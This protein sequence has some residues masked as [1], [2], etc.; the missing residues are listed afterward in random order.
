[1]SEIGSQSGEANGRNALPDTVTA[2]MSFAPVTE[3]PRTWPAI[4]GYTILDELGRGG[5]GVVYRARQVGL[6]RLVALKMIRAGSCAGADERIRFRTEAEAVARLQHPNIVHIYDV[7]EHEGEPFFSL[8]FCSGGSLAARLDGTPLPPDEAAQMVQTIAGAVEH[9]HGRGIVHRDLKPGNVLLAVSDQQSV[10]SDVHDQKAS[11]LT[12]DSCLL[13]AVPK[14]ADF[15]LAKKLDTET[16]QTQSGAILGTPSYMAPE[17]TGSHGGTIGPSADIYALG[18]ILYELLTGRPPFKAAT[19]FDTVLQVATAEPVPPSRLNPKVSRDLET[20]CLRCLQKEPARRYASALELA[21]DLG[22]FL[23]REPIRARPVSWLERSAKW[24][25]RRPAVAALLAGLL[26]ALLGLVGGGIW[27][28]VHLQDALT[29][30]EVERDQK[31]K[32]RKDALE[33][34]AKE[35][36]AREKTDEALAISTTMLAQTH[37]NTGNLVLAGDILEQVKPEFRWGGWSSLKRQAAGSYATLYGHTNYVWSVAFSPDGMLV[38]SGAEDH[39]VRLWDTA[40]GRAV[41]TLRGH[42]NR[43]MSVAFS[44]DGLRLASAGMDQTVR[45]WSTESATEIHTFR[46]HA[47]EVTA[48]AFSP[49]GLLLASTCHDQT[50]KLWDVK[51]KREVR[52]MRGHG[53]L[54]TSVAFSPDGLLLASAGHDQTIR[55]WDPRDGKEVRILRG[56]AEV[57]HS[58]V[59][60]PDGLLLASGANDRT[61]KLWDVKTGREVRTLHGHGHRVTGVAFSADGALVASASA[62]ATARLWEV[63]TGRERRILRGHTHWVTSVAFSPVGPVLASAS[64]DNTVKLWNTRPGEDIRTLQGHAKAVTSLAFGRGGLLA[65]AGEDHTVK[66][67]NIRTGREIRTL[68]GHGDRVFAVALSPDGKLLASGGA[69]RTIIKLWETASGADIRTLRGQGEQVTGLAFSPDGL[70]LASCGGFAVRLWDVPGG[71]EVRS[72]NTPNKTVWSVAF[73]PDG[74]SLASGGNDQ[75]VTI[76]DVQSGR[77]LHAC[78]GHTDE[79]RSVAFSPDGRHV[80][81]AG[82]DETVRIWEVETGQ[83]MRILKGHKAWVLGVGFSPDGLL[84]ASVG[85]HKSINGSRSRGA[86]DHSL[87]LWDARSGQEVRTLPGHTASV[88]AVAFSTDGLLLACAGYD[89]TIKVWDANTDVDVRVLEGHNERVTRVAFS[90]DGRLLASASLDKTVKLWDIASGRRLHTLQGHSGWVSGI[91]FN[92]DGRLLASAAYDGTIRLWDVH[93]AREVHTLRGKNPMCVAFS[94]D[95]LLLASAGKGGAVQLWDAKTGQPVRVFQGQTEWTKFVAFSSDGSVV[96]VKDARGGIQAWEVATG[97]PAPNDTPVNWL[98]LGASSPDEKWSAVPCSP[99]GIL[100]AAMNPAVGKT[101]DFCRLLASPDLSWH[102]ELARDHEAAKNWFALVWHRSRLARHEPGNGANW[103]GLVTACM[104]AGDFGPALKLGDELIRDQPRQAPLYARRAR[105]RARLGRFNDAAMD[106]L[107]ALALVA[108]LTMFKGVLASKEAEQRRQL[109][110]LAGRTY[111]IDMHSAAFDSE[112]KLLD[113][114]GTLLAENDDV[115]PDNLD[116]QLIFTPAVDGSYSIAAGCFAKDGTGPFTVTVRSIQGKWNRDDLAFCLAGSVERETARTEQMKGVALAAT[117][118]FAAAAVHL[119]K[120]IELD[121]ENAPA[122]H[123]LAE[124]L[125]QQDK[126]AE[127]RDATLAYL[128]WLSPGDQQRSALQNRLRLC[129]LLSRSGIT[130]TT[131][132][133]S[134]TATR[135]EQ[136]HQIKLVTGTTYI[137]DMRSAAF[138]CYLKLLDAT[139][140]LLFENDDV[141]EAIILDSRL[142]FTPPAAGT[143]T[144]VAGSFGNH[145]RGEYVLRIR[146]VPGTATP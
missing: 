55:L 73:S 4:A 85:G 126:L 64:E 84:L 134:L 72:F 8:E 21:D 124:V 91:A 120:A 81:S 36:A 132:K 108:N 119:R 139:G 41:R 93:S 140:R 59:F 13:K 62:D 42:A 44:P 76:W 78:T 1:M 24:A 83:E 80:A 98:F 128:K 82:M 115:A 32:A 5:M 137:V 22:R 68:S 45:L 89:R 77:K 106:N 95:G 37:L 143:Y 31:D 56:H 17:Q 11:K 39:T 3:P 65:S 142:I 131:L 114:N 88:T 70:L 74:R 103:N 71:R 14:I 35:K 113:G 99:N 109:T 67:W 127:A 79:V 10:I 19:A 58:V 28:T 102:D 122:Q 104:Q 2:D 87:R 123:H 144:I 100:L 30:A 135:P 18:A 47:S 43:V 50:I 90:P 53:N 49:D 107:A 121:P 125:L 63:A 34:A 25:K 146:T 48:V 129:E 15:G 138:D 86:E 136:R 12:A 66:L 111:I 101:P 141:V 26:L 97:K 112:L 117:N 6:D 110:L 130:Q 7:G 20:I 40:S 94:P 23:A 75:L 133:G 52:T 16:G 96:A 46:G 92:P 145:G 69:E 54:V 38:A 29:T 116:S 60:S 27:F 57:P 51:N 9:A 105:L 61:I 33:S 118:D